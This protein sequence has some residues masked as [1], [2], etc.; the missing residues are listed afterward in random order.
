MINKEYTI[1]H[2]ILKQLYL[3]AD[4]E[5]NYQEPKNRLSLR[6]ISEQ[7]GISYEDLF[8]YHEL[9]HENEEVDCERDCDKNT[10]EHFLL[11]TSKGRQKYINQCY[12]K[13]GKT[14]ARNLFKDNI[15]IFAPTT[16]ILISLIAVFIAYMSYNKSSLRPINKNIINI[17]TN[18][19]NKMPIN[20]YIKNKNDSAN[21]KGMEH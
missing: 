3:E 13:E 15:A 1:R 6:V 12:L 9:L 8:V 21:H 18:K 2:E 14:E 16:S 19:K 20:C 11:L 10:N 17:N 7:T 5:E 4:K